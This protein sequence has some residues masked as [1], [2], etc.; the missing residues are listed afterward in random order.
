MTVF[1]LKSVC[2]LHDKDKH[3]IRQAQDFIMDMTITL[4]I[5]IL[6]SAR[7]WYW[8]IMLVFRVLMNM[9]KLLSG[10]FVMLWNIGIRVLLKYDKKSV[11][12]Y[13]VVVIGMVWFCNSW[14]VSETRSNH[15]DYYNFILILFL[16]NLITVGVRVQMNKLEKSKL[17]FWRFIILRKILLEAVDNSDC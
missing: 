9:F 12:T 16:R 10:N 13:E 3:K 15:N 6:I 5:T 8:F 14:S 4:I 2:C 7:I 1:S 17:V 11:L